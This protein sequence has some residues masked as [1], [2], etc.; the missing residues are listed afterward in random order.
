MKKKENIE[1]QLLLIS[2][3]LKT[4]ISKF[5]NYKTKIMILILFILIKYLIILQKEIKVGL[6]IIGKKENLYAEEYL[7][8]Y[9]GI[10]FDHIFIYDN[11]DIGD[12]NL[13]IY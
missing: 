12:E 2:L 10:G 7:N 5:I 13:K 9:I 8:Y 4:K 3:N 1:K 6:C 11:N